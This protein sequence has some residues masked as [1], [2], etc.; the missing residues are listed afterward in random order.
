MSSSCDE[1]SPQMCSLNCVDGRTMND[2]NQHPHSKLPVEAVVP[3][4]VAAFIAAGAVSWFTPDGN[5]IV[6][7]VPALIVGLTVFG[8]ALW[9]FRRSE[10]QLQD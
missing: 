9:R 6:T 10:A 5:L 3:G 1:K 7:L 4:F 2:A 8:L